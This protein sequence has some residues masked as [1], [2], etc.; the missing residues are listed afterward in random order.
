LQRW[1]SQSSCHRR[2][3]C[4]AVIL[5]HVQQNY[6]QQSLHLQRPRRPSCGSIPQENSR[7]G[8]PSCATG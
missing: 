2:P 5:L 6:G 8:S 7:P 1:P 3:R 4:P